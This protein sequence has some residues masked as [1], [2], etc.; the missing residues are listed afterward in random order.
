M[1]LLSSCVNFCHATWSGSGAHSDC[2]G[3]PSDGT[4]NVSPVCVCVGEEED[5]SNDQEGAHVNTLRFDAGARR[6]KIM[7]CLA[8]T[9]PAES[10]CYS[11]LVFLVGLSYTN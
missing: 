4:H 9:V 8:S 2:A 11:D 1:V 10:R 5:R 6:E 7:L 3:S